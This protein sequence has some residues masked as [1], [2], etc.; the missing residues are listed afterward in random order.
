MSDNKKH[1]PPLRCILRRA[2][3]GASPSAMLTRCALGLWRTCKKCKGCS[4]NV[5]EVWTENFQKGLEE[6]LRA[7]Q[8]GVDLAKSPDLTLRLGDYDVIKRADGSSGLIY[9]GPKE[10]ADK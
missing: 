5:H 2:T 6:G 4:A 10:E 1:C 9:R 3:V 7:P 8:V